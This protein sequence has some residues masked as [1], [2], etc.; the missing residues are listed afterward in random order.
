MPHY[1]NVEEH[2]LRLALDPQWMA[3]AHG[4]YSPRSL[5]TPPNSMYPGLKHSDGR[6]GP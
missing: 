6:L 2:D 4:V 1:T 3:L 5:S